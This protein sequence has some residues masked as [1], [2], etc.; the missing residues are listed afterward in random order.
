MF[1]NDELVIVQ[2]EEAGVLVHY[3]NVSLLGFGKIARNTEAV[4]CVHQ[5][6]DPNDPKREAG[7]QTNIFSSV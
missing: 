1:V 4:L 5:V 3:R 2:K 6:S 7:M